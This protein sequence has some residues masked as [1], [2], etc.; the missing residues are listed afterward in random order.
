MGD[1]AKSTTKP[2]CEIDLGAIMLPLWIVPFD[3]TGAC[4]G[5]KTRAEVLGEL[6]EGAYTDVFLFSHGWNNTYEQAKEKYSRF[7]TGYHELVTSQN[8]AHPSP[9]RPLMVGV[10]WP[11]IALL[12]P[13][14]KAPEI[15]ATL[16]EGESD[17]LA[18]EPMVRLA[19]QSLDDVTRAERLRTLA[20]Q[21]KVTE[22]EAVEL[23]TLLAESYPEDDELDPAGESPRADDVMR[24]WR[25][26]AD[27]DQV[28]EHEE[29]EGPDSFRVAPEDMVAVAPEA[30][31]VLSALPA[32]HLDPRDILRAF[33]VYKMKDRA[34]RVGGGGVARLLR[35]M[36]S[37]SND[38]RLHLIGHSY[39]CRLLLSAICA[40]PLPRPARSLLLL[41]PAV[42][43]LCFARQ[44]P[45]TGRPGGFRPALS[46]VELPTLSTFSRHDRALHDFFHIAVRRDADLGELK[47]AALGQVPSLYAALGGW[48]PGGLDPG[49]AREVALKSPPDEYSFDEDRCR[50]YALNGQ[51]GITGHSD[52]INEW[53]FWALYNQV[54]A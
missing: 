28:N 36:L 3:D 49:E 51:I 14:E 11:S 38:A 18:L 41:E 26:L 52:V 7:I 13:W 19:Q 30:A 2:A 5:P 4:T 6:A 42:N 44:V 20:E 53:T 12:L 46:R 15:A 34:G 33:T 32:A 23:S 21:P 31:G 48:G 39:G 10:L 17:K 47:A 35:E 24:T 8:L 27:A 40:E 29:G 16:P 45:K 1:A 22:E 54:T 37:V 50:L 9:Y 25:T 43:Y